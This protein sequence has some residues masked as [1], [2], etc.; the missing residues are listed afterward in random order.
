MIEPHVYQALAE[1]VGA[2]FISDDIVIRQAYSRDPHPSITVR[3]MD[4]DPVTVPDLVVL[5]SSTEEVQGV[6][7]IANRY[8]INVVPMGSGDN[9]TGACIPRRPKT[10]LLDLKRM[11]K[12]LEIDEENKVIRIQPWVSYARIQ[13]AC[14][15]LGLW[16]GG[17]PAAPASNNAISNVLAYGGE[18]QTALAYGLG[19]R[20]VHS[21]TVVLPNGDII[22]TGSHG[23]S[24]GD[25]TYWYGPGPDLKGLWEMG[26]FGGLGVITEVLWKLHTWIGGDW[27]TEEV[28][29]HP[30]LPKNHRVYW[31]RFEKPEDAIRAGHD[32]CYSGIG[33]GV[34]LAMKSVAS[35]V[36]E[37]HHAMSVKRFD[38]N[39]YEP[40]WMYIMLAG[41]SPRQ[42]DYEEKVLLEIIQETNGEPLSEEKRAHV[43]AWN[44]D[45]FRSGDFVRWI[46][47]GIYAITGFGRG[48]I[49]NMIKVHQLQQEIVGKGDIP[50][51]NTT[52]PW[53]YAHERGYWWVDE[54]DLYGDQLDY[55]RAILPM[56][57]EVIKATPRNPSGYWTPNEPH[58]VWFGPQI[59]PN[60]HL[61]LRKMKQIFDPKDTMNPDVLIFVRSREKKKPEG[62]EKKEG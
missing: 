31:F 38:E 15:K 6:L 57:V 9:L 49:E 36:G 61:L 40:H 11:D 2:D 54:R 4:K 30:P 28:Y 18:Y 37:P 42:L 7:R 48:P 52:W 60:F 29:A 55:A 1:V 59:G 27:P 41:F 13:A 47:N 51:M 26:A 8:G 32:I 45:C 50:N 39:Y 14:M 34:N 21:F 25:P 46:R 22:R 16:N 20:H 43:D 5:P 33:V 62:E 17:T 23:I 44:M 56:I 12:I 53:Y 35:L 3:K 24:E 19:I 58:G 10:M